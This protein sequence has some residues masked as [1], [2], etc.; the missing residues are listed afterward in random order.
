M[1]KKVEVARNRLTTPSGILLCGVRACLRT[2]DRRE[3]VGNRGRFRANPR[4]IADLFN[5]DLTGIGL[6]LPLLQ[7]VHEF[8][9][10]L[11]GSLRQRNQSLDR[12]RLEVA[13][14][15]FHVGQILRYALDNVHRGLKFSPCL[16]PLVL[17]EQQVA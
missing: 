7:Q 3:K 16:F 10:T 9:D 5:E 1:L 15:Q 17:L 14:F 12:F 8:S 6:T 13:F 4:R 2:L 11:L